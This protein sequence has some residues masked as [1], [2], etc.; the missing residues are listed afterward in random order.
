MLLAAILFAVLAV[1]IWWT[2]RCIRSDF[3]ARGMQVR[4]IRWQPL[5][6]L[7]SLRWTRWHMLYRVWYLDD[8]GLACSC[9]VVATSAEGFLVEDERRES[10]RRELASR[11]PAG[12]DFPWSSVVCSVVGCVAI[13]LSYWTK[14]YGELSLPDGL[15]GPGLL[16]VSVSSAALRFL[17]PQ[18]WRSTFAI[19]TLAPVGTVV[20]RVVSDGLQ[21]A[22]SHNL[23]PFELVIAGVVGGLAV[24]IGM[25]FGWIVRRLVPRPTG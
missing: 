25:G 23:F 3:Q 21:D 12:S 19:M 15:F 16:L 10:V 5:A 7:L 22:T 20:V 2:S 9:R 8:R 11:I 4:R 1:Q 17:E 18:R 13:G 6:R 14:S 24:A